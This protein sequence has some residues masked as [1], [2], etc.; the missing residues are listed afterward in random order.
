MIKKITIDEKKSLS[1]ALVHLRANKI[2]EEE[3]GGWYY[4]NKSQFI[5]RHIKS[6]ALL[7]RLIN[8]ARK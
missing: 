2:H 4:G 1:H 3:W 8:E 6:I 5:K 7:E